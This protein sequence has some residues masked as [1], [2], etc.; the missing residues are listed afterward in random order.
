M[1]DMIRFFVLSLT[2]AGVSQSHYEASKVTKHSLGCCGQCPFAPLWCKR[3]WK[4]WEIQ[5][6][7]LHKLYKH[8]FT[9][10][11]HNWSTVLNSV[12]CLLACGLWADW[13]SSTILQIE[14][15]TQE[16]DY[17]LIALKTPICQNSLQNKN[18]F[19]QLHSLHFFAILINGSNNYNPKPL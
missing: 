9:L 19:H 10:S 6:A 5:N 15:C 13:L 1:L 16:Q 14:F 7:Y 3:D 12:Q 4:K 8:T 18:P 11:I 2:V 17:F